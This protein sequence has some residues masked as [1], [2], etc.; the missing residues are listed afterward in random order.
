MSSSNQP[1]SNRLSALGAAVVLLALSGC[2]GEEP[3]PYCSSALGLSCPEGMQCDE[4]S[5][6]CIPE[7][8]DFAVR[9]APADAGGP[10]EGGGDG[11]TG[12][13]VFGPKPSGWACAAGSECQSGRCTDNVCCASASCGACQSCNNSASPGTCAPDPDGT[14]C[15]TSACAAGVAVTYTCAA[16]SCAKK[17]TK[18][19]PYACNPAGTQC[20]GLCAQ[21]SDCASTAY[22]DTS[23]N[24]CLPRRQNGAVCTGDEQCQSSICHATEKV[25]CDSACTATCM[26]CKVAGKEGTCSSA[27]TG[28]P[29]GS[30]KACVEGSGTAEEQYSLCD[31]ASPPTCAAFKKDCA[32]YRCDASGKS[33]ATSCTSHDQCLTKL[34]DLH[35]LMGLKNRCAGTAHVCY[36]DIYFAGTGQ[37]TLSSPYRK[38]QSC[39]DTKKLYVAVYKGDY[40]E[41]LTVKADVMMVAMDAKTPL[42]KNGVADALQLGAVLEPPSSSDGLAINGLNKVGLVG[43]GIRSAPGS[44]A[45]DALVEAKMPGGRLELHNCLVGRGTVDRGLSLQGSASSPL[46]ATLKDVVVDGLPV[47]GIHAQYTDLEFS[48]A[49]VKNV[50]RYNSGKGAA[51]LYHTKGKLKV[52]DGVFSDNSGNGLH[53]V[54]ST[55]DIDRAEFSNNTKLGVALEQGSTGWVSNALA[56]KNG[57]AGA[58]SIDNA[59]HPPTFVNVT[60]ADNTLWDAV[61]NQPSLPM[62]QTSSFINAVVWSGGTSASYTGVCIFENSLVQGYSGS[63]STVYAVNPMFV[64]SGTT[65]YAVRAGS[66]AIDNG[67]DQ[68]TVTGTSFTLPSKDLL[69]NPRKVNKTGSTTAK[70]DIGAYEVQ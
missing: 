23:S 21:N 1:Y 59:F 41:N 54:G 28:T 47:Y 13:L 2:A 33:C 70:V 22:C 20:S 50:D 14:S 48:S 61:C 12:D 11:G 3:L 27:P 60:L 57:Q 55:V 40:N 7:S 53:G 65:P 16:G 9:P 45:G 24:T 17:E 66:R 52:R 31:G 63:A 39:L 6:T 46:T 58:Y 38:V 8:W 15:G 35:D 26:S 30:A 49:I 67:T 34:C 56:V 29:C 36:V 44:L 69:G 43:F 51:G 68:I 32:P 62:P 5:R 25:C 37:G 18:C 4:P 19:A 42:I 64:G 10:S